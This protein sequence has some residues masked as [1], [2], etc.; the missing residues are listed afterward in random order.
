MVRKSTTEHESKRW[1]VIVEKT[2]TEETVEVQDK[3]QN[4]KVVFEGK[5]ADFME[6][7]RLVQEASIEDITDANDQ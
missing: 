6:I 7:S 1:F 3:F 2:Q 4:Q 5:L